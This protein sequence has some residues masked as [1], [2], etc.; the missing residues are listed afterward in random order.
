MRTSE[1]DADDSLAYVTLEWMMSESK[2]APRLDRAVGL[3]FLPAQMLDVT[4]RARA[5]GSASAIPGQDFGKLYNSR[6]G[7][8]SYYRYQPRK[9]IAY[10]ESPDRTTLAMQD[11]NRNGL[12]FEERNDP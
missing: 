4:A 11:P 1:A 5:E 2:K 10:L 6:E 7:A 3:R 12:G 8:A 9:L